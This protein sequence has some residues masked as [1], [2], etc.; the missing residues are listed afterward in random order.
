MSDDEKNYVFST[1]IDNLDRK[2]SIFNY[3]ILMKFI[4]K[5]EIVDFIGSP[6]NFIVT[7]I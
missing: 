2:F 4:S 3:K 7:Y 1:Y 5:M 6:K